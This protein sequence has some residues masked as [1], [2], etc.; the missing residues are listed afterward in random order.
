MPML[1]IITDVVS[2][3]EKMIVY[4]FRRVW[5]DPMM[6]RVMN[7]CLPRGMYYFKHFSNMISFKPNNNISDSYCYH[8]HFI[9]E[10]N[11]QREFK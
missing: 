11:D 9:V 7:E 2:Y 10:G 8:S 1:S 4:F 6:W 5:N 3:Q